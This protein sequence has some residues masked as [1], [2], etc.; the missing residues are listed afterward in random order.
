MIPNFWRLCQTSDL[1]R[2]RTGKEEIV[3]TTVETIWERNDLYACPV[4]DI[5]FGTLA[6]MYGI[7]EA[8]N[9][10]GAD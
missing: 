5:H 10:Q 6:T 3:E 1:R 8:L 9:L 7:A 4:Q 2:I